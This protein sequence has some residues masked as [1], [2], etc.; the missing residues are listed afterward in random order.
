MARSCGE[1]AKCWW[2]VGG[3]EQWEFGAA[4]SGIEIA[5]RGGHVIAFHTFSVRRAGAVLNLNIASDILARLS[6]YLIYTVE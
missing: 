1:V 4:R 5:A 2:Q 6:K 3:I